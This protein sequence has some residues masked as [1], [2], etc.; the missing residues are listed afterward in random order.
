MSQT[1]YD[2]C[3]EEAVS[4]R[5]S[6]AVK[7]VDVESDNLTEIELIGVLI[8]NLPHLTKAAGR[9]VLDYA[10]R[11]YADKHGKDKVYR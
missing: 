8:D 7:D 2:Y 6:D 4:R 3:A 1:D 10:E 9:R 11:V 5:K